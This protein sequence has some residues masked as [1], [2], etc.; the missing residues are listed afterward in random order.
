M[1]WLKAKNGSLRETLRDRLLTD[2]KE[3]LNFEVDQYVALRVQE[4]INKVPAA[5]PVTPYDGMR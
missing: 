2:E 3:Q 1:Q 4:E 5:L